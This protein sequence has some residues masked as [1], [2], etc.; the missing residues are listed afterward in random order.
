M[1]VTRKLAPGVPGTKKEQKQHKERLLAVRYLAD[2]N[3]R[4]M[5]TKEVIIYDYQYE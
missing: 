2:G 3:G 5:K 4:Y 1:K